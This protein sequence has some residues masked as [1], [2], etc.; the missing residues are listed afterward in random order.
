VA[1]LMRD[2]TLIIPT[3]NGAQRLA[4]L[5]SY[6]ESEKADCLV[7]VLDSSDSE[8][9]AA[10]RARAKT[11]K[12]DIEI[13]EC[14]GLQAGEKCRQGLRKVA[15]DFCAFCGDG[16]IVILEGFRRSLDTLRRNPAA[17]MAQGYSFSFL[18][19]R[20]GDLELSDFTHFMASMGNASPVERL[21]RLFQHYQTASHG[22]FRTSAVQRIFAAL[23]P[24]STALARDLLWS[25]LAV[26]EGQPILVS[27]LTYG[28]GIDAE[29]AADHADP[30][31]WFCTDPDGLIAGYLHYRELLVAALMRRPDN[32]LER[33]E[34]CDLLDVIHLRYFAQHAPDSLLE[35]VAQQEIAG[36]DFADYWPRR[37]INSP[38]HAAA[39][40]DTPQTAAPI[41]MRGRERR[42]LVFPS[43]Y[44]PPKGASPQLDAIVRLIDILDV[45]RPSFHV[46][47]NA[48]ACTS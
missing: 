28:R 2:F 19:R 14:P 40:E 26:I 6:L 36:V 48:S 18:A 8:V 29:N 46:E 33:D 32:E 5:L 43:F 15:T 35:F 37:K 25:A 44:A 47:R 38:S 34:V 4:A 23:E 7:L 27:D 31:E 9:L 11:L 42:Y 24:L 13:V 22:I 16:D 41:T 20:D 1:Q 30:L 21:D 12:L 3:C 45:Y 17:P 39:G 10:N